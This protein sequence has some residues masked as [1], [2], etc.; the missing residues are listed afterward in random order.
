MALGGEDFSAAV[1]FSKNNL[2]VP[3]VYHEQ[4][5]ATISTN[6]ILPILERIY[7]DTN[8]KPVIAPERNAGGVYEIE[9]MLNSP[10]ATKFTM[11]ET[12]VGVGDQ[13]ERLS[14]KYGWDT[15]TATRPKMLENLKNA[16]DNRLITIYDEF[17]VNEM[18]SFI[19]NKKISGWKAEA[20]QGAHD[21]LIMSLAI[22]WQLYQ[23]EEV[24]SFR[25]V[26]TVTERNRVNYKKWSLK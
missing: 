10:Y 19:V 12:K 15:N 2:D 9:R 22:A 18:Y 13:G 4:E 17:L 14:K 24:P 3:L 16:I 23:T 20:E 25:N 7:D 26:N 21:D 6:K 1:F 8:V 5:V 11:Y